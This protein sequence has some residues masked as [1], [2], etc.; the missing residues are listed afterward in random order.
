MLDAS[1][2]KDGHLPIINPLNHQ[3]LNLPSESKRLSPCTYWYLLFGTRFNDPNPIRSS[4]DHSDDEFSFMAAMLLFMRDA[5]FY[6]NSVA[7]GILIPISFAVQT[8][9]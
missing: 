2:N 6:F 3:A 5:S 4:L 9:L 1:N 8:R 7:L